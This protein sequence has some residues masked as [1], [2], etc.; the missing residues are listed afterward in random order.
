[1]DDYYAKQLYLPHFSGYN[2]QGGS[3]IGALATEIGRVPSPF[4]KKFFLPAAKNI[5]KELLAQSFP[6][7]S[8]VVTRRNSPR[9]AAIKVISKTISRHIGGRNKWPPRSKSK[10][11]KTAT[12]SKRKQRSRSHFFSKVFPNVSTVEVSHSSLDILSDHQIRLFLFLLSNKKMVQ[13]FHPM[14]RSLNLK[15]LAIEITFWTRKIFFWR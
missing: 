9:T 10:E 11:R 6:E 1:M 15:L 14:G 7:I 12:K 5:G 4:A 13:F 8:D 2:R 3:G